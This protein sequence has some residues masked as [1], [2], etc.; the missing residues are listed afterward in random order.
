[1][2]HQILFILALRWSVRQFQMVFELKF[3]ENIGT[4]WNYYFMQHTHFY[5]IL[6]SFPFV[7][8]PSIFLTINPFRP[9]WIM[10]TNVSK[11]EWFSECC[12]AFLTHSYSLSNSSKS[13]KN[14]LTGKCLCE[15][16]QDYCFLYFI[17]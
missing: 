13:L 3:L 9:L 11:S 15:H 4:I 16:P 10:H 12:T 5:K 14:L 17:G 1:M 6:K 8:S 7:D 2:H